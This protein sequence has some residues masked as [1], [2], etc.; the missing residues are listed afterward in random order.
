MST[1]R[2][3]ILSKIGLKVILKFFKLK[4]GFTRI[5]VIF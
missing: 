1:D 3:G 4:L 2:F 5:D